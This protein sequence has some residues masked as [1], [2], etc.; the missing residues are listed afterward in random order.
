L[1]GIRRFGQAQDVPLHL[2]FYLFDMKRKLLIAAPVL[3]VIAGL[4]LAYSYYVEPRRLV[5]N[6]YDLRVKN[7]NPALD[8]FKIAAISDVHGGS[9]GVTEARLRELVARANEQ[10]A[11]IIVLLGDFV[12]QT[13]EP[14]TLRMP[15]SSVAGNLKGFRARFGTYAVLGNHDIWWNSGE[16]ARELNAAGIVVLEN[17]VVTIEKNGA[18]LRVFGLEDHMKWG[19]WK[20][21]SDKWKNILAPTEDAG[22]VL[23]LEHS[24]DVLPLVTGELSISPRLRLIL[25]GHTHGGQIWLP[26]VG[27]PIVPSSYGQRYAFGHIRQNEVDMFVTTGVGTSILPFRFLV[28]PEIAVVTVYA[29]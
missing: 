5:V 19:G 11:D 25:A 26:L 28:P 15:V 27:S 18:K 6:H 13:D 12:S 10:D 14:E 22:D 17:E 20:A 9:N 4:C 21:T 23:L 24:P 29:E 3:L 8:G 2:G 16:V 1:S 7:W